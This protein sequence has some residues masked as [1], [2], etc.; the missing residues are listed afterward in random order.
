MGAHYTFDYRDADVVDKIKA[1]IPPEK[2]LKH[3]FDCVGVD[4]TLLENAV[5]EGGSIILALPP[6]R[7]SPRHHAEMAIAGAIH[8][9]E[10]FKSPDFKFHEGVEPKDSAG[11]A[12]LS[13]LLAW[14]I[15]HAGTLY[16]PAR[17]RRLGGKG[18][19]DAF[20]CFDL[21]RQ[22]KVS[23]EKVVWRMSETP[24]L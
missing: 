13:K 22:N 2:H 8:D 6:S 24:G 21:M 19:Y 3:A 18:M 11:A 12:R 17:V 7:P 23:A 16:Q 14:T 5:E 15:E 1:V 10:T 4:I 9:L 20:E